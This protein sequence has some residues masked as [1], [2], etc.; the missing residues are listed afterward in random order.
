VHCPRRRQHFTLIALAAAAGLQDRSTFAEL[1]AIVVDFLRQEVPECAP[2][3]PIYLLGESFGGLLSLAVAA[4][5]PRRAV[6]ISN[7]C[8]CPG[9]GW[10]ASSPAANPVKSVHSVFSDASSPSRAA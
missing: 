1:V 9:A 8:W 2:T 4:G 6:P 10:H 3:R 5:A 7:G